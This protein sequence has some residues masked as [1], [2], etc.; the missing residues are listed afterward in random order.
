M[1]MDVKYSVIIPVYNS[2]KTIERCLKS[3][4]DQ[5]RADVQ[6]IAVDDGSKDR[7]GEIIRSFPGVEYVYQENG[8]VSRARNHGLE[9]AKGTYVTFVDSDDF[10]EPDYF[11]ALDRAGDCDLLVFAHRA[12]GK[13]PDVTELFA[14]LETLADPFDRL[15]LLLASRRIMSPWDK[16]FRREIIERHHIR[17]IPGMSV[18]EDFNFCLACAMHSAQIETLAEKIIVFD[19]SNENSLSRRYRPNLDGQLAAVFASAARTIGAGGVYEKQSGILL[20]E[21]DYLFIKHLFSCVTEEIK[22]G[23]LDH[24]RLAEICGKFRTRYGEGFCGMV[25]R[26]LRMALTCRAYVL[27]YAVSYLKLKLTH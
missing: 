8:G 26:G 5:N 22:G 24:R 16:R 21:L 15:K 23:K 20:R 6:I 13:S 27:F 14:V 19:V 17:F 4:L 11:E 3:L 12:I 9:L 18:G 2:E 7:S 1:V 25:H 10:V